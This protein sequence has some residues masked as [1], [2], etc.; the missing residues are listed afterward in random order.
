MIEAKNLGKFYGSFPAVKDASFTVRP[1]EIVGLLGPNG[2]GK[3]TIMKILTGYHYPSRGSAL[4]G[5]RDVTEDPVAVKASVGY[6]PESAPVYG[7]FT[8]EEYLRFVAEARGIPREG[9]RPAIEKAVEAC[10]LEKVYRRSID[11]L[12]KG[13]R[14]RTGLAQAVIHDPPILILDEPT[15]GLDPN[16]ILEIRRLIRRLGGEKTVLLSTHIL[17]EVEALC[18]RILILNEGLIAAEGTRDEIARR[19]KGDERYRAAIKSARPVTP[20]SLREVRGFKALESLTA[21]A[22]GAIEACLSFLPG[23]DGGEALFD[24]AVER[25]FK[26]TALS[27]ERYSLE[28]LFT[29]LTR[30]E[31]RDA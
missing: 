11:R 6:L 21:A 12:S 14:Q 10:G 16:Q 20:E 28:D 22:D 17:Q 9:R 5:G 2:A 30:E 7:E 13:Y 26:L 8:V 23:T 24:W 3:T 29:R 25:G 27:R 18:D 19:L 4:L 31:P 1:A 15:A